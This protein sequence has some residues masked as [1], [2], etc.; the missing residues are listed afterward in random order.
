[1]VTAILRRAVGSATYVGA[2]ALR[3][4]GEAM[5]LAL[6]VERTLRARAGDGVGR[7][8]L[9]VVDTTLGSPHV[10]VIVR[11]VLDSALTERAISGALSG[12]LVDVVARDVIRFHVLDRV[13]DQ[14][15]ASDVLDDALDQM[16]A[17]GVP[18]RV[19]ERLLAD[20][21]AEEVAARLLS[22]PHVERILELAL[23]S[24]P[25][26]DALVRALDS[27][28]AARALERALQSPGA[29]RLLEFV[30]ESPDTERMVTRIVN[31]RVVDDAVARV[32]DETAARLPRSEALW[33][34]IDEIAASP[35]VTAAITRQGA[36]FA[37]QVADE[38]R[39]RASTVDAKLERA[40][41][42]LIR[43]RPRSGSDETPSA[44]AAT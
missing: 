40:A 6:R 5:S 17:G 36:G 24:E 35:A 22:G 42:R 19:A 41:R 16:Q 4:A 26:Q 10:D 25:L 39:D 9:V 44:A 13:A 37:D 29:E 30:L 28:A 14:L 38:V 34:L 15:I 3:P 1:V 31:S 2:V 20:G 21:V 23:A 18:V 12:E 27:P 11:H 8:T 32:V 33:T 7:A 43:R